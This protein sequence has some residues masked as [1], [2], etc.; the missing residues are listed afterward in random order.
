MHFKFNGSSID[1]NTDLML[2]INTNTFVLGS[3]SDNNFI[4]MYYL[5]VVKLVDFN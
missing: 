4:R 3:V 1:I 2:E 5:L